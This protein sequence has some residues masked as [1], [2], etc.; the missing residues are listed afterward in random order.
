MADNSQYRK[1]YVYYVAQG[2]AMGYET[3]A[4]CIVLVNKRIVSVDTINETGDTSLHPRYP[5]SY[6][7]SDNTYLRNLEKLILMR[8]Q[9]NL[10]T[11][12]R[13]FQVEM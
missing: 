1:L 3:S 11:L 2:T 7:L 9:W 12:M 4:S 10:G 13:C 5:V 8:K 6:D